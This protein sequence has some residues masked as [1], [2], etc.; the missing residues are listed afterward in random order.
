MV[1]VKVTVTQ[2]WYATPR[3]PRCTP[4]RICDSYLENV[5]DDYSRN[6]VIGKCQQDHSDPKIIRATHRHPTMHPYNRFWIPISNKVRD[7]LRTRL[8]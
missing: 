3:I 6:E 5:G 4:L 7:M 8:F 1:E 2:K